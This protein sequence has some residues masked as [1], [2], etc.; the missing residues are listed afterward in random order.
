MES[1]GVLGVLRSPGV[2][3]PLFPPW[4]AYNTGIHKTT[5]SSPYE[6]VYG[7]L[8]HLPIHAQPSH[9]SF[10]SPNN[11]FEQLRKTLRIY[12]QAA[13]YHIILQ[14]Q[15]SKE[16]YDHNRQDPQYKIGDRVLTR[17][18]GI[19]GKLDPKFSLLPKVITAV[20]HSIYLVQDED[21]HVASR[22]HVGDLRP[23]LI[24]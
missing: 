15:H 23:I 5:K 1:N 6:L 13:K 18:Q 19:R 20:Y 17:I 8:P 10:N 11:Y 21:S 12:H 16:S 24:E 4:F 14:Q 22:V 7:R 3:S 2:R 9:V